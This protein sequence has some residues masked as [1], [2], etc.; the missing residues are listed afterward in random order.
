MPQQTYGE[1]LVEKR[2]IELNPEHYFFQSEYAIPTERG[3]L[4]ADFVLVDRQRGVLIIEVK[5][6]HE[7]LTGSNKNQ[8][9]VR[10]KDGQIDTHENPELTARNYALNLVENFTQRSELLKKGKRLA[11]PWQYVV[12][13][14]NMDRRMI[15][16]CQRQGV[17]TDEIIWSQQDL[18]SAS[19]FENAL[20]RVPW[21][22]KILTPMDD[23]VVDVLRGVLNP[24]LII[25]DKQDRDVGTMSILQ[26]TLSQEAIDATESTT[27][28]LVRGVAGSGKSL[29]LVHR[30]LWLKN[31][32]PDHKVL[33][34]T[35]NKNLSQL[36]RSKIS[37]S[38]IHVETFH[39]QCAKIF[40][41][42]GRTWQSPLT[43]MGWLQNKYQHK[44]EQ[45]GLTADF[46][47]EE[48]KYRK[49][50]GLLDDTEYLTA[51][52]R[53]R[54]NA[55][56]QEKRKVI[57]QIFQDYRTYQ[58]N[59]QRT[60]Q[61]HLDWED[62]PV[63]VQKLLNSGKSKFNS[64][65]DVILVDEAQDFPPLW[66]EIIRQQLNPNGSLFLSDD[67]T[68]SIFRYF[69]WKEKGVPVTGRTKILRVP[70]RNTREI[71]MAAHAMIADD[72]IIS[73]SEIPMP[74]LD[75]PDLCEGIKPMLINCQTHDREHREI[76]RLAKQLHAEEPEA[77][78]AILCS[79]GQIKHY[80][81]LRQSSP[82]DKY[83]NPSGFAFVD[84]FQRM[85][86]LEFDI[87]LI[88]ALCKL[89]QS[90]GEEANAEFVANKRRQLFTAMTRART[91]LIMS[92]HSKF[93]KELNALLPHVFVE[94]L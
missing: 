13:L 28:R 92:Y 53:G 86:G 62:I 6:W 25:R 19:A 29:V 41:D 63:E 45:S 61:Q 24:T 51:N 71:S 11:F 84:S 58:Q 73:Q 83:P 15:A 7:L 44:I 10:R 1:K 40:R 14:P 80:A 56:L 36:L 91:R 21:R 50:V 81:N 33:V 54:G 22:F 3:N 2:L 74:L 17:L 87:V 4:F 39:G 72:P 42:S 94:Q 34:V 12:A 93:P 65:Y 49:E 89:F 47:D 43:R 77:K 48:I 26:E 38:N 8:V 75:S 60:N 66:I 68:Q 67:P 30:A 35:F 52:R 85:K 31:Q 78:I 37:D 57:N 23:K 27:V 9:L 79:K 32:Y 20:E 55:L 59:L 90:E 69:S 76:Q 16:E 88:P 18:A 5:D 70:F 82:E 64:H 46:V